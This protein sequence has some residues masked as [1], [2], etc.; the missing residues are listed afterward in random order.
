MAAVVNGT[1]RL[2][3]RAKTPLLAMAAQPMQRPPA[4]AAT[5]VLFSTSAARAAKPSQHVRGGKQVQMRKKKR[6]EVRAKAAAP[7]ERKALRTRI[8]LSNNNA[9]AVPGLEEWTAEDFVKKDTDADAGAGADAVTPRVLALP[10]AVVDQ[11]RAVGA[12]KPT[13]CFPLFRR[14]SL[15][16]RRE[17]V[18][19]A[20][21]LQQAA[22]GRQTLRLVLDGERIAGK[23]ILLLQALLY[24]FQHD[25]VVIHVPECQELTNGSTEY[26]VLA[27]TEPAQ[28]VQPVYVLRLLRALAA[29]N[30]RILEQHTTLRAYERLQTPVAAGSSLL[31]LVAAARES[32]QA[33]PVFQALWWELT[34]PEATA[35]A[36][37][38]GSPRPPV[39]LGLDGLAHIMRVSDY[40]APDF[41]PIHAHDLALVRTFVDVLGGAYPLPHGGAVLAA[42]SRGNAPA[43]PTLQL[44]L[45]QRIQAQAKTETADLATRDPFFRGYD[46]RVAAAL[47]TVGVLHLRGVSRDEARVLME[48]WAASGVL[49]DRIDEQAVASTWSLAGNGVIGEM[50]RTALLSLRP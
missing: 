2:V 25:W 31:Q 6:P 36:E 14:P 33:W 11:L 28:Y 42:T 26:G 1:R 50:E 5:S 32:D 30:P 18:E 37:A 24:G 27:G 45:T 22:A 43:N 20:A 3:W 21:Q 16:V 47:Q 44:A 29:A 12:F 48:Y 41:A 8:V 10:D 13:Q 19:L 9:L 46:D 15:L 38:A 4:A 39:L 34:S 49:R 35:A 40:H 23:S 17:T 7:G